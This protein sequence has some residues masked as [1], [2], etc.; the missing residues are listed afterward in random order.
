MRA[1]TTLESGHRE[2]VVL[3]NDT[4]RVVIDHQGGMIP[5]F[6]LRR[7]KANLNAH[8]IPWFRSMSPADTAGTAPL[9]ESFWIGPLLANIAGNFPCVPAFGGG[10]PV[11]GV[12]IPPHGWTANEKWELMGLGT[13]GD[14]RKAWAR[15]GMRSPSDGLVLEFDKTDM[16]I[17]GESVHYS[18]LGVKNPGSKDVSINAAWHNTVGAPFLEPGCRISASAERW[19]SAPEGSEF[20]KTGRL[21]FGAEFASLASAPLR[22]GGSTDLSYVPGMIGFTDFATGAIPTAARLGWSACVNERSSIAYVTW[23]PGPASLGAGEI[24]LN[25][26]DLWLQ[27]GGRPFPPWALYEGGSDQT[28]CLGM[29]NSTAAWANGLAESRERRELLGRPTTV[30]IKAG[31]R[32]TLPYATGLFDLRSERTEGPI[33]GIEPH[34]ESLALAFRGS[35]IKFRADGTFERLRKDASEKNIQ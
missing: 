35:S 22:G 34:A 28:F 13:S 9:K 2:A 33:L 26:N 23:F 11:E 4:V 19:L 21:A 5:E 14:G 27:Y 18:L 1:F 3:E 31:M 30:T 25:F 16:L 10:A 6:S 7:G 8:W 17:A 32:M 20:D 24:G 12:S 29:E 15:F